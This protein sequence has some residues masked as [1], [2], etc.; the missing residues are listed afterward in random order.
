MS[1]RR[2]SAAAAPPTCVIED[3]DSDQDMTEAVGRLTN[4]GA[5]RDKGERGKG[6]WDG[7][8]SSSA[9]RAGK[10]AKGGKGVTGVIKR[11]SRAKSA[12]PLRRAGRL[13]V[14]ESEDVDI[15][16]ATQPVSVSCC[17]SC[18]DRVSF[19]ERMHAKYVLW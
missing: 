1:Q 19:K 10:S 7:G 11:R 18:V 17:H 6:L 12:I 8:Q 14:E 5:S 4:L 9:T 16:E 15:P 13:K 2:R 3:L